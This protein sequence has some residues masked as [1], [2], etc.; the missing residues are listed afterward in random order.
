MSNGVRIIVT[1]SGAGMDEAQ[2]NRLFEPFR[3]TKPGG[4]GLGLAILYR[5]VEA[6]GG[7]IRVSSVKGEGTEFTIFMPGE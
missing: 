7:S 2:L 3:T 1:D 6:H 4:S 5:I